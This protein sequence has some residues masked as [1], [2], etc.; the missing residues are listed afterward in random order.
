MLKNALGT[1]F[2]TIQIII[3]ML[4][5]PLYFR[6]LFHNSE[7]VGLLVQTFMHDVSI[8]YMVM[9]LSLLQQATHYQGIY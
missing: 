7:E 2:G 9:K 5:H 1:V 8:Q 6:G 4:S 3:L